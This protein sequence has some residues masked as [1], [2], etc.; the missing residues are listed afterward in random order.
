[1]VFGSVFKVYNKLDKKEY[2]V[3]IVN[4]NYENKDIM[5]KRKTYQHLIIL[6]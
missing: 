5:V 3:K 2:A 6:T 1:M 4:I